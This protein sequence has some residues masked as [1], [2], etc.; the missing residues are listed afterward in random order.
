MREKRQELKCEGEA[1]LSMRKNNDGAG[2]LPFLPFCLAG[3]SSQEMH[4]CR[5]YCVTFI[6]RRTCEDEHLLP[7]PCSSHKGYFLSS[8]RGPLS[9]LPPRPKVPSPNIMLLKMMGSTHLVNIILR[10]VVYVC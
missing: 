5:R 9:P 6:T 2:L 7:T 10:C 1:S 3:M 4:V 8:P